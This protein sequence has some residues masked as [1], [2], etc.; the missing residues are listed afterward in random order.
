MSKDKVGLVPPQLARFVSVCVEVLIEIGHDIDARDAGKL[1]NNNGQLLKEIVLSGLALDASQ[2][3]YSVFVDYDQKLADAIAAGSYDWMNADITE[4]HFPS[5]RSG[6]AD[7]EIELVHFDRA[8]GSDEAIAELGKRH[9]CPA[10]L[11]ELLA[12]GAQYPDLQHRCPI[13]AFGS[14]LY[15]P[16]TSRRVPCLRQTGSERSLDLGWFWL[17]WGESCR[18]AAVRV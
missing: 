4:E 18:F 17:D 7:I 15:T 3:S 9:L 14:V 6:K 8:I 11:P 1:T 2:D 12:L 16:G 13:L 5:T 10:E